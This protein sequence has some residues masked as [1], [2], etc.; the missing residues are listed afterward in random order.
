MNGKRSGFLQVLICVGVLFLMSSIRVKAGLNNNPYISFSPDGGAYTTNAGDKLYQWYKENTLVNTGVESTVSRLQAGQHFYNKRVEDVVPVGVWE[1]RHE[2]GN[3]SHGDYITG[4]DFHGISYGTKKCGGYYYSGWFPYCADCGEVIIE[5]LYYMSKETAKSLTE[6]DVS[7]AYFY[8][9]PHCDNLEQAVEQPVHMCKGISANRYFVRYHANYGSG[10]MAKSIHMYNDSNMYEGKEV[11]PQTT[12]NL[13]TYSRIGYQF[14]GW[15]TAQDGS[16]I[17]YADGATISNLS[18]QEGGEIILYAQWEKCE[19]MLQIDPGG[20][21]YQGNRQITEVCGL[22]GESYVLSVEELTAPKGYLVQFDTMGGTAV[23]DQE[24]QKLFV[25]WNRSAP[26]YGKMNDNTYTFGAKSGVVDK[27]KAV[28]E[29]ASI[30]L[31]ETTKE[32]YSFGGW[33][34]DR[35]CTRPVGSAGERFLPGQDMTLYAGWVDLQL[36][37]KDNY[38]ANSGKGAVDLTWSQKDNTNKVY[39]I[40]QRTEGTDWVQISSAEK[41]DSAYAS[42][43]SFTYTGQTG[44]FTIPFSGF[45]KI[46]L[47]GAQGGSYDNYSGGLGGEVQ[48]V[49]YLEKGETLT[50]TIGGQNGYNGGGAGQIYANGGGYSVI[51][52]ESK[53]TLFIA[54]GGGGASCIGNGAD[55]GLETSI[56][57]GLNGESG[58]SGGGGGYCGGS[59]GNVELHKHVEACKHVHV[60]DAT[61]YGGCYTISV[62]CGSTDFEEVELEKRFYYGNVELVNGVYRKCYCVRCGSYS[63]A[64]HTDIKYGYE[65]SICTAEYTSKPNACTELSAYAPGCGKGDSFICGMSEQT[66][67]SSGPAYGGSSYVNGTWCFNYSKTAGV[68]SGDGM[69]W[70]EAQQVGILDTNQLNGVE[71]TDLEPPYS[72][73]ISGVKKTAVDES[74]IRISFN[75]PQDKGTLYYHQVKSYDKGT[76]MLLCTSNQT[77]NTLTSG[78]SGYY[79]KVDNKEDT[80]VKNT[81]TYY[82]ES[83]ENPFLLETVEENTKYLHMAVV[84]KAGNLSETV[85]I[86]ISKEDMVYWPIR[87]DKVSV[88]GG[89]NVAATDETDVYY[90]RADGSTPIT[91][92]FEGLLC[93]SARKDYQISHTSFLMWDETTGAEGVF[94]VITPAQTVISA[95]TYTYPMQQLQ[96]TF[97]GEAVLQ[98]DGY[99]MTK[100]YNQCKSVAL[101]QKFTILPTMD[102]HRICLTPQ[103]GAVTT[104]G[105][106][107]SEAETDRQHAIW[108]VADGVSPHVQGLEGLEDVD[109]LDLTEG[110]SVDV[111]LAAEDTGCGLARFY[112]E[113]TNLDNGANVRYEDEQR[114]GRIE[115]TMSG[116]EDLFSGEFAIV[117]YASDL[118]GNE[119][120]VSTRLMGLGLSAYVE[121]ILEPHD[122]AFKRGESGI[123][124][125]QTLGYVE[126]VE[127]WFPQAFAQAGVSYDQ[128]Y[129]YARPDYIQTE[130]LEFMI[131]LTLSDGPQVIVVK[132]YKAGT[133]LE[134]T[135]QF[136]TIEIRGSVVDEL[137]TRLR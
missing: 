43:A 101:S 133:E 116:E 88:A 103:A 87:T 15:N 27:L 111:K 66:V 60:G 6:V 121:R 84:D 44:S 58:A 28:Y 118:V 16:G 35:D 53:G 97:V 2:E 96:K 62:A 9:C 50:Y 5:K 73:D 22:Y 123:L 39:S 48:A 77:A 63:C 78:V 113:I 61:V 3:C 81:D 134:Q 115:F 107:Y 89:S 129:E 100:R 13:N 122:G 52:C 69:L 47:T 19:S 130:S 42:D 86:P 10:Y 137:R 120:V 36:I 40:F 128:K 91:V 132:A 98:D 11:T 33:Y 80:C 124:H 93:G 99:T 102:G 72:I 14:A 94:S 17:S 65:C 64:G 75:R 49:V 76:G 82:A 34:L 74:Q 51:A 109:Y 23:D 7:K 26:F 37:A 135:P 12:L 110:E 54:G 117:V 55:G 119:T 8:K 1:V 18:E 68:Q 85:H 57:T 4:T 25:E 126:C 45:Y 32:G 125:I 108:L 83:G 70:I 59:A 92:G 114:T 20:G 95:G 29:N 31:P 131:P 136:I 105:M 104:Q 106:I 71:A 90:V 79:Y 21:I 112:V 127:V 46:T 41:K 24:S 30:V 67:V 56:V 38:T